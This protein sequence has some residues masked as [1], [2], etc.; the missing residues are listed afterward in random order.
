[1]SACVRARIVTAGTG[2]LLP[3]GEAPNGEVE[4][5]IAPVGVEDPA[6][7]VGKRLISVVR[8][9]SMGVATFEVTLENY[10]NVP[11][12]E[13]NATADFATAFA[14]AASFTVESLTSADFVVNPVF[15]GD[16]DINLLAAGNTLAVGALGRI[17]VVVRVDP[18][19]FAGPYL[20]SSIGTGTSPEDVVVTDVSQDGGDP[21]PNGDGDPNNDEEP[22]VITFEI[23][24]LEIPTMSEW[25]LAMLAVLLAGV[26]VGALRRRNV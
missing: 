13:V 1:G 5:H 17:E 3:T 21:D 12:S 7:G 8:D 16:T 25:G 11:L 24:V 4:D 23:S 20:C 15:D 9:G 6:I 2:A 10:G 14:A 19:G 18:G 26:G 22:T